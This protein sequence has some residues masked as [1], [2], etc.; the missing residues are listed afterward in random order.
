[1]AGEKIL[2]ERLPFFS[3]EQYGS[4]K[5]YVENLI[6]EKKINREFYWSTSEDSPCYKKNK[7][8]SHSIATTSATF[9]WFIV[10]H[11]LDFINP[12]FERKGHFFIIVLGGSIYYNYNATLILNEG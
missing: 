1:M 10:M 8:P 5:E 6:K 9:H 3:H 7:Y 2:A 4:D 11:L 12:N